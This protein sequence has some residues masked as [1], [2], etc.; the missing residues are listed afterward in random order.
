MKTADIIVTQTAVEIDD[1]DL[2]SWLSPIRAYIQKLQEKK[3]R[4]AEIHLPALAALYGIPVSYLGPKGIK[5]KL[6]P[7]ADY[8]AWQK[9]TKETE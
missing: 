6:V 2:G 1:S 9:E 4:A 3:I 8:E 5:Y 7:Q